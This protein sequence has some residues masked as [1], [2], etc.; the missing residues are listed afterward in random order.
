V[1]RNSQPASAH[2]CAVTAKAS[3][4]PSSTWSSGRTSTTTPPPP[5]SRAK[6]SGACR[7]WPFSPGQDSQNGC[8]EKA[9]TAESKSSIIATSRSTQDS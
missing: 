4:A 1:R 5:A 9:V 2:A 7:R 3:A 8:D 6:K